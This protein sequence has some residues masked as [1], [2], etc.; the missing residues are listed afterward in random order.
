[1][2]GRGESG[3]AEGEEKVASVKSQGQESSQLGRRGQLAAQTLLWIRGD[4]AEGLA[5]APWSRQM[6]LT[7]ILWQQRDNR[8]H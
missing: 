3:W 1:M 4:E 5:G 6:S 8:R 2:A 7:F